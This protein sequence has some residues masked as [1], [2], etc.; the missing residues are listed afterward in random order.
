[1]IT[2]RLLLALIIVTTGLFSAIYAAAFEYMAV[3]L[4][5][6]LGIGWFMLEYTERWGSS[7]FFFLAFVGLAV[8]GSLQQMPIVLV[9]V[10][11]CADLAAWDLSRFRQRIANRVEDNV[12]PVLVAGHLRT[13][14]TALGTGFALALLPTLINISIS[15]GVLFFIILLML[16]TLRLSMGYL[17]GGEQAVREI[18]SVSAHLPD[19]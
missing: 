19:R 18:T 8:V 6:V 13:L 7:T 4:I 12:Q 15:F 1:M 16:L 3:I 10:G 17:H 5:V 9:L 2:R 11:F 14:L